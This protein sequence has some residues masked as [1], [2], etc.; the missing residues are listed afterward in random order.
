MY[1]RSRHIS[2][3]KEWVSVAIAINLFVKSLGNIFKYE[4]S[5]VGNSFKRVINLLFVPP[6]IIKHMS[7]NQVEEVEGNLQNKYFSH[8]QHPPNE[9]YF[10]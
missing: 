2:V 10:K 8:Y 9:I 1:Q 6:K 5:K 3:E 7:P 4:F